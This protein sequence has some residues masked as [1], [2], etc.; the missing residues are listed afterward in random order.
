MRN[1]RRKQKG[2]TPELFQPCPS[3]VS[4]ACLLHSVAPDCLKI[5]IIALQNGV[6]KIV[7]SAQKGAC[8]MQGAALS[9]LQK[10]SFRY[11]N[12]LHLAGEQT[13]REAEWLLRV[14]SQARAGQ[15]AQTSHS[16]KPGERCP[17]AHHNLCPAQSILP[18]FLQIFHSVWRPSIPPEDYNVKRFL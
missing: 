13:A 14:Q 11:C 7:A 5:S 15:R 3:E 2:K 9:T 10:S 6:I 16:A 4:A 1:S 18:C 17:Q 12:H 8:S